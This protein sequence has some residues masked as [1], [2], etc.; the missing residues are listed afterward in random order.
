MELGIGIVLLTLRGLQYSL[1]PSRITLF[2]YRNETGCRDVD[3]GK[4]ST[5]SCRPYDKPNT[6]F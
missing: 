5:Y 2:D 6:L 4:S 3:F 1:V